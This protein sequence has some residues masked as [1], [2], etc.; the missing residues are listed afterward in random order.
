[1]TG[2]V[3]ARSRTAAALAVVGAMIMSMGFVLMASGPAN[4]GN[5]DDETNS[6]VWIC[7]YSHTPEIGEAAQTVNSV[8]YNDNRVV[9]TWGF[10]DQ[11]GSTYVYGYSVGPDAVEKP[12]AA[13]DCP[14]YDPDVTVAVPVDPTVT[15]SRCVD[16]E[17]TAA[18]VNKPADGG[19]ITYTLEGRTVTAKIDDGTH[20][21]GT[22]PEGWVKVDGETATYT[23][24]ESELADAACELPRKD[25]TSS[26]ES[27]QQMSCTGGVQS[28]SRTVTT[29]Y[30]WNRQTQQFDSSVSVGAWS[31]WQ[32]VRALNDAEFEQL[33]C[34]PDQPEPAE[35]LG[36]ET[37]L[38]CAGLEER[39]SS[40]VT[41]F[42]W[43]ET[44][45]EYDAVVGDVEW[46]AWVKVRDLT[47]EELRAEGCVLGEETLV[48]K[49]KP[50]QKPTVKGVER[51]APP[52]AVP[53]AV[54]AGA[55]GAS[56][57]S[58]QVVAQML[59]AGGMLLLL[60]GGWIGLGRREGGAHE[61]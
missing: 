15:A 56:T 21:W 61:A 46:S 24:P 52:A 2:D 30:T 42:V 57:S 18:V 32:F 31:S 17:P 54:A 49:P 19:G 41:T 25:P 22:L 53:T 47:A 29:A 55:A 38:S 60:A 43:N 26:S 35:V 10:E 34:R 51:V 44:T 12:D 3:G 9:G 40:Q 16:G 58:T 36:S 14:P 11:H 7:K 39:E 1:M 23:V 5:H 50:E 28:R 6:K 48:P 20:V 13:D 8:D 37:R 27:Q 33:G 45:R 4:A 59:M